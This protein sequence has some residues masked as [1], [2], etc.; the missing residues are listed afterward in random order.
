VIVQRDKYGE[1]YTK[2]E[3]GSDTS[4]PVTGSLTVQDYNAVHSYTNITTLRFYGSTDPTQ[5]PLTVTNFATNSAAVVLQAATSTQCGYVTT[6]EQQF[7]GQ[8]TV[9]GTGTLSVNLAHGDAAT[10]LACHRTQKAAYGANTYSYTVYF[11]DAGTTKTGVE[12]LQ[13]NT[14]STW[15]EYG[16]SYNSTINSTTF[17]IGMHSE[18]HSLP[19]STQTCYFYTWDNLNQTQ[20]TGQ[21]SKIFPGAKFIGGILVDSNSPAPTITGSR[22]GNAALASLLT[23]LDNA[24]FIINSTT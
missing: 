20:V 15:I 16:I 14:A 6:T 11:A 8:K 24:G 18:S 10:G 3:K 17:K 1:W 22:G 5:A 2:D 4:A 23:A 12:H 13:I 7:G 9:L 21:S 19:S